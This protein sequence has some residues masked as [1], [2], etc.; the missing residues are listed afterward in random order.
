MASI[1]AAMSSF[2][3]FLNSKLYRGFDF[4]YNFA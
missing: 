3:V 2:G 4:R 1:S